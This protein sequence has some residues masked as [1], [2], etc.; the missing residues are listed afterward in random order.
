MQRVYLAAGIAIM[1]TTFIYAAAWGHT[2]FDKSVWYTYIGIIL[3]LQASGYGVGV[4][5][6][7]NEGKGLRRR[8][9]D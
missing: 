5:V 6:K 4:L 2:H 7:A 3:T 8:V 1:V 9:G